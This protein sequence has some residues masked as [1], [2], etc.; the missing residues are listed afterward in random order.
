LNLSSKLIP[1]RTS[2][3]T[4]CGGDKYAFAR[5]IVE[6]SSSTDRSL[7]IEYSSTL[8]SIGYTL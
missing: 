3:A 4:I 7:S 2:I 1:G 5:F 6:N 8:A